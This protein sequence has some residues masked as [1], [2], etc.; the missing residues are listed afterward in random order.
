MNPLHLEYKRSQR[1]ALLLVLLL[2]LSA[3]AVD[4]FWGLQQ[5][6]SQ[7]HA[8]LY[9]ATEDLEHQL[10]P[11]LALLQ[12]L[13][14][15]AEQQLAMDSQASPVQPL[16]GIQWSLDKT[17]TR[18]LSTAEQQM[19]QQLQPLLLFSQRSMVGVKQLS[20]V[21]ASGLW[22][23]PQT[24][25]SAVA[26]AISA[27]YWQ[28]FQPQL[29]ATMPQ[30]T[31]HKLQTKPTSYVLSLAIFRQQQLQGELLLEVD[32]PLLLQKTARAQPGAQLQLFDESGDL[33]LAVSNGELL[34]RPTQP[35]LMHHSDQLKMLTVLP[36]SLHIEAE[37]YQTFSAEI[38]DFIVHFALFFLVL[39]VL[40]TYCRRRF[41]A[42][43]L[44]PFQRL[45]VHIDRLVRGDAQGVRNVP[46]DWQPLFRQVEQL[47]PQQ[48]DQN[49]R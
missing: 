14:Q 21:S 5:R 16:P 8:M 48:G 3:A 19:L 40:L 35:Q 34:P 13:Q 37:Q 18:Q 15:E 25:Q 36:L 4:Y 6:L 42:K 2:A 49:S 17:Q 44:S 31:L 24:Q 9:S 10:T 22:Y 33:L 32:L 47:K 45:L 41:R 12:L 7:R 27:L 46:T 39:L 1:I 26:E 30:T 29:R 43:V 28:Q 20:Y 38:L 11:M 23:Q